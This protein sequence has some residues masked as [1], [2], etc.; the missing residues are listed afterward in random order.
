M[1]DF[2]C[3]EGVWLS[4]WRDAGVQD[5]LGLDGDYVDRRR[6]L[7]PQERFHAVDLSQPIDLGRRFDLAQSL[8]V[9]EHL[10]AAAA[11]HFVAT[12]T[13]HSSLALFSAAPPGQGGAHHVNEQ[14]YGYWRDLFAEIGPER[15]A[16]LRG[17]LAAP[18]ERRIQNIIAQDNEI[19]PRAPTSG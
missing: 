12:I 9:A 16:K 14:P 17:Y 10:P 2:G 15:E 13:R 19:F 7:I 4:A 1:V 8:E 5:V 3:A 18:L 6:L 11:R